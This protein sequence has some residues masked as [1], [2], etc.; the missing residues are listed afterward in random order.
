VPASLIRVDWLR[1]A[2]RNRLQ[3]S[4]RPSRSSSVHRLS[5][6]VRSS[7]MLPRSLL[8]ELGEL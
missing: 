1:L 2:K 4:D 5:M 8:F 3:M 7:P 6:A